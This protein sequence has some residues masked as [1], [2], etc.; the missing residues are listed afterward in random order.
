MCSN[1]QVY[2]SDSGTCVDHCDY[3]TRN[4]NGNCTNCMTTDCSDMGDAFTI[5]I[6][7]SNDNKMILT[8]S[9]AIDKHFRIGYYE[10]HFDLTVSRNG[11]EFVNVLFKGEY[12]ETDGELNQNVEIAVLDSVKLNSEELDTEIKNDIAEKIEN[13]KEMGKDINNDEDMKKEVDAIVVKDIKKNEI[14]IH[15]EHSDDVVETAVGLERS[16]IIYIF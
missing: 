12:I 4:I 5:W 14:D 15:S 9:I 6:K 1:K 10:E 13:D 16:G 2:I 8:P 7:T 11:G 3:K